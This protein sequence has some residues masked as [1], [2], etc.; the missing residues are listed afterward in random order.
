MASS[1]GDLFVGIHADASALDTAFRQIPAKATAAGDSGGKQFA[2][3]FQGSF[4]GLAGRLG[5]SFGVG[6]AS[7]SLSAL[8]DGIRNDRSIADSIQ[9]LLQSL[10]VIGGVADLGNALGE[11][12]FGVSAANEAVK[13]IGRIEAAA[14]DALKRSTDAASR[15]AENEKQIVDLRT[16]QKILAAGLSDDDEAA[17][18]AKYDAIVAQ[19]K[20][21]MEEAERVGAFHKREGEQLK[22]LSRLRLGNAAI[23]LKD[24]LKNIAEREA[25]EA[26]AIKEELD[27][28]REAA[29]KVANDEKKR[30]EGLAKEEAERQQ[31]IA[32][33][34]ARASEDAVRDFASFAVGQADTALGSFKF[35]AF[36]PDL[37]KTIQL[38][39][40]KAV[41]KLAKE[42]VAATVG[43][44]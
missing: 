36:P 18:Q 5:K 1:A 34:S 42:P 6:L 7:Q 14:S 24:A 39:I 44:F 37:Q 20:L 13:E 29:E 26:A 9:G 22:E 33:E 43:V 23:E 11:K 35:D 32:E 28:K 3:A 41:E 17:A 21:A 27:A 8:A 10:P 4:S 25:A 15:R 38:R 31:R 12:M 30:L 40:A 2:A 19:E 16:R